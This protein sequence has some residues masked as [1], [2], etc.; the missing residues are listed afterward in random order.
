MCRIGADAVEHRYRPSAA[1][2]ARLGRARRGLRVSKGRG[3]YFGSGLTAGVEWSLLG[4]NAPD[5]CGDLL[6]SLDSSKPLFTMQT[7]GRQPALRHPAAR[8]PFDVPHAIPDCRT[9]AFNRIG[10]VK[11][12]AQEDGDLQAVYHAQL[13][14]ASRRESAADSVRRLNQDR[15]SGLAITQ[16]L[17]RV[18]PCRGRCAS[19]VRA[20]SQASQP[21]CRCFLLSI[22]YGLFHR[23]PILARFSTSEASI[24]RPIRTGCRRL[25]CAVRTARSGEERRVVIPIAIARIST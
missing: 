19:H 14:K 10:G 4:F 12:L 25:A 7:H 15:G 5:H 23:F 2:G 20:L 16:W 1:L 6:E 24:A 18:A 3:I 11:G 22:R 13:S 21:I 17:G 9:Y 8:I